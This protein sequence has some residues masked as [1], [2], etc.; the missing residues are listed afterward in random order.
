MLF[1]M[2]FR[3]FHL[4]I[5]KHF[6]PS[7]QDVVMVE[8]ESPSAPG[9]ASVLSFSSF[10]AGPDFSQ[11]ACINEDLENRQVRH[12]FLSESNDDGIRLAQ[13]LLNHPGVLSTCK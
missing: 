13:V 3:L 9:M 1:S 6:L 2:D 11:Q 10:R 4:I 5:F 8:P 7:E 12:Q